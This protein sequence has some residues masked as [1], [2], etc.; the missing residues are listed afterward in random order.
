MVR[1]VKGI[2]I[3]H[4]KNTA[5]SAPAKIPIPSQ[6]RILMSMH[7]GNPANPVVAVGDYVKLGQLIGEAAGSLS[8]PVHAS[9]SGKI[10][11]IDEFDPVSG[12]KSVSITIE[13]DREQTVFEGLSPPPVT[14]TGEFLNAVAGSGVV[15]LGGAGYPTAPK[16]TLKEG[17]KLDYMLINGAECEPYIT[18]DT[19]TMVDDTEYVFEGALLMQKYLGPKKTLI[20]IEDNKPQA[21]EKLKVLCKNVEGVDVFVLPSNYPQGER[22]VLVYNVTGRIVPEGARLP[23]VGCT[24]INCTTVAVF[25]RYIKTGM[26]L[27]SRI[28]TVDGSAVRKPGNVIAPIGTPIRE[29]FDFCGGLAEDVEKI[30]MGGP[31]MGTAV[32]TQEMPVMKVTNAILALRA[33]DSELPAPSVCIKCGRCI[34]NC[35]MNLMPSYMEEAFNLKKTDLLN[36]YKI[37]M[38][39]ECSCCSY[40]CPAKRPLS[41]VMKLSK[42]MVWEAS[43][44]NK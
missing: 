41:Q 10:K 40:V 33:R 39:A 15:G 22:K 8:S 17:I 25:A 20:C 6:V 2:N 26:P 44:K 4:N 24:V 14:S 13:S 12:K 34:Q 38:C 19:R 42:N 29:L 9:V 36:I 21:I 1:K 11:S 16:L 23:D 43:K 31:M 5:R 35:P 3:P 27:T 7:S 37:N 32:P 28:I 30:I 18:S